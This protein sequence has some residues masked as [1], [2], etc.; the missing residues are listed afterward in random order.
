M[1]ART[2][3]IAAG[4]A[5]SAA[6]IGFALRGPAGPTSSGSEP[7]SAARVEVAAGAV[8]ATP[9]QAPVDPARMDEDEET[10][11]SASASASSSALASAVD[12]PGSTLQREL[13][14][15][16]RRE[17]EAYPWE[18]FEE[19]LGRSLTAVERDR[20][21][22]LR[23]EHGL[24]LA[25]ARARVQR[26]ELLRAEFDAWRASRAAEFRAELGDALGCSTEQVVALLKVQL[27][28]PA[29]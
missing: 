25:E 11:P 22:D 28:E 16:E 10:A 20:M 8:A 5:A 17:A 19:V 4:L 9:P 13:S 26:G 2:L 21:R 23:K 29:P 1:R 24:R 6:G 7:A 14:A 27:D 3:W 15:P 12:E 18:E